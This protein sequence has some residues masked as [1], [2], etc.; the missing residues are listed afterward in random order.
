MT[1]SIESRSTQGKI[2]SRLFRRN[3][4]V[5]NNEK[6]T[7]NFDGKTLMTRDGRMVVI[8]DIDKEATIF[9]AGNKDKDS[10]LI[11]LKNRSISGRRLGINNV[12]RITHMSRYVEEASVFDT[13]TDPFWRHFRASF[14]GF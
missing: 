6:T 11:E 1:T 4:L 14:L 3:R 12:T 10:K 8:N 9:I 2:F 7:R 5:L 13:N